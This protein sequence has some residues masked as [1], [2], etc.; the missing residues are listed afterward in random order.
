M[1]VIGLV[2]QGATRHL[3]RMKFRRIEDKELQRLHSRG[4]LE[5]HPDVLFRYAVNINRCD[6]VA[7]NFFSDSVDDDWILNG[8]NCS[9][10]SL[11]F[12]LH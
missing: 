12:R 7:S 11:E 4:L 8:R 10:Y 3:Q 2:T 1:K 6:R 9:I 5:L